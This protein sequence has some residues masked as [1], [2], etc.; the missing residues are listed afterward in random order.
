MRSGASSSE[1]A[2]ADA[3]AW[4]Q[5]ARDALAVLP[6][7]PLRGMLDDLAAY[8]V[9]LRHFYRLPSG[10]GP[11]ALAVGLVHEVTTTEGIAAALVRTA[12]AHARAMGWRVRPS[13]SYVRS[14]MRRHPET[15]DLLA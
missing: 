7:H 1:A 13:C 15:R 3:L 6:D 5:V 10:R 2:R 11:L 14:Y 9:A 12:L 8:V 4:A